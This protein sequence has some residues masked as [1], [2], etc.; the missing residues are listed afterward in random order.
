MQNQRGQAGFVPS[1]YV[2]REKPSLFD[3]I[4]R[5]VAKDK[6]K[7]PRSKPSP[8]GTAANGG[9]HG[10]HIIGVEE[11]ANPVGFA[12]VRC[13]PSGLRP[14]NGL[15]LSQLYKTLPSTLWLP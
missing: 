1:N 5:R 15:L 2:K 10:T 4:R 3:S 12:T 9:A 8:P 11:A 13:V 14:A 7:S 6:E